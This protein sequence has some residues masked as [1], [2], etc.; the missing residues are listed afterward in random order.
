MEEHLEFGTL[1]G[2]LAQVFHPHN[3]HIQCNIIPKYV[4]C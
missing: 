2:E 3:I 4:M 1:L